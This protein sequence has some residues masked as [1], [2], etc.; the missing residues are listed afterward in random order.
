MKKYRNVSKTQ[1]Y[2]IC[3]SSRTHPCVC[4]GVWWGVV[5]R[6]RLSTF[7]GA[8]CGK[9]AFLPHGKSLKIRAW[10]GDWWHK[11]CRSLFLKMPVLVLVSV[12]WPQDHFV[13]WGL[14]DL[15]LSFIKKLYSGGPGIFLACLWRKGLSLGPLQNCDR[16]LINHQSPSCNWRYHSV[17]LTK[18]EC[19]V[20]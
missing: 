3:F 5:G 15:F 20:R 10:E 16:W 1:D 8:T 4:S 12:D 7:L 2:F 18:N 11:L 19:H 9:S 17:K 6:V 13:S 14:E